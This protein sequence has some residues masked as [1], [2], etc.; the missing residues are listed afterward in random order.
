MK[1]VSFKEFLPE[2]TQFVQDV[3]DLVALR[4][5]RNAAIQF[6]EKTRCWQMDLAPADVTAGVGAYKPAVPPST[7]F[8]DIV[9]G[10]HGDALLIPKTVEELS[11]I[12]RAVDWRQLQGQPYYTTRMVTDTINLVPIPLFSNPGYLKLR[13]ALA[14][15]RNAD[16][17]GEELLE[18]YVEFIGFGARARL[19]DTPGQP[20]YDPKSAQIYL[21]R[22]N[23]GCSETKTRIN[24]SMGRSS[25]KIEFQRII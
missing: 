11:N 1:T 2:V 23:D 8:V 25:I 17:C 14:P 15:T 5:I 24:K 4:A 6:C 10:W 19:Y 20:Y 16:T 21:K 7:I 9:E 18:R 12:Y 3:P 13:V 22:F